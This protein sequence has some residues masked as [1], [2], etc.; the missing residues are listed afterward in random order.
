M[1]FGRGRPRWLGGDGAYSIDLGGDRTL[2]LFGDSFIATS[3]AHLG[4]LSRSG[5][6]VRTAIQIRF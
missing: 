2:W 3:D 5:P 6:Y 1:L 4:T